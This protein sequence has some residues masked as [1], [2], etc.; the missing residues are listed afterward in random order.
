MT[1]NE[2]KNGLKGQC[3]IA[4]GKRRRSV[5]LGWET[6]REI[7]RAITLLKRIS[8]F[9]TKWVNTYSTQNNV[10]Q[11]RPQKT[12][13]LEYHVSTDGFVGASFTR[14]YSRFYRDCPGLGY[15]GLSD[16]KNFAPF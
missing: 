15:T 9:R 6:G 5:A 14:G 11:F 12:F 8:L 4:Q 7:V 10:L 16:R 1:N 13:C 2:L 3:I